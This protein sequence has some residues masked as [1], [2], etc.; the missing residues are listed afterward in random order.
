MKASASKAVARA[1]AGG[2]AKTQRVGG[3]SV[4]LEVDFAG[5][6]AGRR[7]GR[8]AGRDSARRAAAAIGRALERPMPC[9]SQRARGRTEGGA[10]E[11]RAGVKRV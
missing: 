8:A 9:S 4:D 7:A 10:V 11:E 3:G 6:G 1:R 5:G 2:G